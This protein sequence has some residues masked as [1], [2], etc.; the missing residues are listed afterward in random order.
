MTATTFRTLN[1]LA[2][3]PDPVSCML[4]NFDAA[5]FVIDGVHCASAEG[6]IMAIMLP[7]DDP[8]RA[9]ALTL[10]GKEAKKLGRKAERQF[11]WWNGQRFDFRST[12]HE[13]LIERA[14]RAKFEQ[15]PGHMAALLSTVG[16]TLIHDVGHPESPRTSLPAHVFMDILTRIRDGLP[17]RCS[18]IT[19]E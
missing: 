5:A 17:P 16:V 15:N 6:F 13:A 2:N 7:P 11:V 19:V 12:A 1:I 3:S 14:L 4:S 10:S 18:G 9:L 8:N